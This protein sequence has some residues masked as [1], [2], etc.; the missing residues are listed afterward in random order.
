[1][2]PGFYILNKL[3]GY[4]NVQSALETI[5]LENVCF[6]FANERY[7]NEFQ[8]RTQS[9]HSFVHSLQCNIFTRHIP[10]AMGNIRLIKHLQ[11]FYSL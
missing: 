9:R 1:M 7:L 3:L 5:H 10:S 6:A 11:E 4:S 8:E 2:E